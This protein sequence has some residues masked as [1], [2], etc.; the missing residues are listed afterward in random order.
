MIFFMQIRQ[1]SFQFGEFF[2]GALKNTQ[3]ILNLF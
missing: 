2:S 3:E 1:N